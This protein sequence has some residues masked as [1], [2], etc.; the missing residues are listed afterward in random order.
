MKKKIGYKKIIGYSLLSL[1]GIIIILGII[2]IRTFNNKYFKETPAYLKIS[3]NSQPLDFIWT[4]SVI[5]GHNIDQTAL[6]IPVEF[7]DVN[8]TMSMQFDTGSPD[9]YIYENCLNSLRKLG[10]DI[11]EIKKDGYRFV[12]T[13]KLTLGGENITLSRIKIYPNYGGKF[14]AKTN[15]KINLSIGTLGSDILTNRITLIDFKNQKIQFFE[16]RPEWMK[17]YK[18]FQAFDFPGRRIMLPVKVD[19][20]KYEFLYDS[21]CST[22]GLITTKQRF[23]KYTNENEPLMSFDVKSW[24]DKIS[25]HTKK[26]DFPIT[27]GGTQLQLNKVSCVDMYAFLQPLVTPFTRIGGW[28]G[29]QSINQTKLILDTQNKEFIIIP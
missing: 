6:V 29:N 13:L 10:V 4:K 19:G 5:E 14:S 17:K 25:I 22:F 16:E 15:P 26:S 23:K 12:D 2:G 21:G 18:G 9:S 1:L 7:T 24:N 27:I 3:H 8:L 11:K 28:M 20:N